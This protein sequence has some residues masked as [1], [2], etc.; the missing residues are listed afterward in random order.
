MITLLVWYLFALFIGNAILRD[1]FRDQT[2]D[3]D[4]EPQHSLVEPIDMCG[5]HWVIFGDAVLTNSF[6]RL[7]PNA[8]GKQGLLYNKYSITSNDWQISMHF[9]VHNGVRR[10]NIGGDG[11][12]IWLISEDN[13]FRKP[14]YD[15]KPDDVE[16][17]LGPLYGI[18]EDFRG[19]GVIFDS[20]DNDNLRDNPLVFVIKND[21][22]KKNWDYNN[23]FKYERENMFKE[24]GTPFIGNGYCTLPYRQKGIVK[25]IV[26]YQKGLLSV[27]TDT[28]H[29]QLKDK[30]SQQ[31]L[32]RH[33]FPLIMDPIQMMTRKL[34]GKMFHETPHHCLTLR[35]NI[36]DI[37]NTNNKDNIIEGINENTN[38]YHI[39]L[40]G[41]TG[42]LSDNHDVML[43]R[44]TYLNDKDIL[45]DNDR[46][47]KE[48]Y[49]SN[50]GGV[51][52]ILFWV[53]IIM[54]NIGL[55]IETITEIVDINRHGQNRHELGKIINTLNTK[56]LLS[57]SIHLI[58]CILLILTFRLKCILING[59]LLIVRIYLFINDDMYVK[60]QS[61]NESIYPFNTT[62]SQWIWIRISFL[63]LSCFYN[64]WRLTHI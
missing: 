37:F 58:F 56:I 6:L 5:D 26:R 21:G 19:I 23:D 47:I 13:L 53:V 54:L 25:V 9:S 38:E 51:V 3:V 40:S 62:Y 31:I 35:V 44:T 28:E 27:Y 20:Y 8:K 63:S 14:S 49:H 2:R 33:P 12:G 7:T 18:R 1:E 48:K 34:G 39:A 17:I 57:Y 16:P 10:N 11:F 29:K 46:L 4:D 22:I 45:I 60:Y 50:K 55:I 15:K 41:L 52:T 64:F 24:T 59:P 32:G 43:L 36:S 30:K 42:D 61:F